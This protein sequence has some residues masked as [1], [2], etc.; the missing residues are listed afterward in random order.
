VGNMSNRCA[1]AK[2]A[3]QMQSE[4]SGMISSHACMKRNNPFLKK[5]LQGPGP[6][7]VSY[8]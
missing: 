3:G 4:N 1:T 7:F 8:R 2:G 6:G 5:S